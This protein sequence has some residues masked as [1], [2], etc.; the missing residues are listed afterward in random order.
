MRVALVIPTNLYTDS[1]PSFL[2]MSDFPV[3]LA[4]IAAAIKKAGHDV[5]GLNPNNCPGYPSAREMLYDKMKKMLEGQRPQLIGIGGLSTDYAFIKDAIAIVRTLAPEVPIVCGGGIITHDAEFIFNLLKPDYCIIGEAEEVL[6]Q[7]IESLT[8]GNSLLD[9]IPNLGYW[10]DGITK[11]TAPNFDYPPVE[12]RAFPDY[13][14]F[15]P[16]ITVEPSEVALDRAPRNDNGEIPFWRISARCPHCNVTRLF[17]EPLTGEAVA[18][19]NATFLTGCS[20]CG[21]RFKIAVKREGLYPGD[22]AQRAISIQELKSVI[23]NSILTLKAPKESFK[24]LY[25]SLEFTCWQQ[26]RSWSYTGNLGF[27]EGFAA[28][29]ITFLTV[30]ALKEFAPG[31]PASWLSHLK[32]I[33]DGKQFEQV[34]I[35]VV[36]NNLDDTI[37]SY[38]ATL[39]PV[40]LAIIGESLRYPEE[41]YVHAPNLKNRQAEVVHRLRYMTHALVVDELDAEWL[42]N[43]GIV[44]ALWWVGALPVRTI[45]MEA[46]SP[47]QNIAHFSG[48]LYGERER[49]LQHPQLQDVLI[50]QQPLEEDANLPVQFDQLNHQVIDILN[51]NVSF[52][53]QLLHVHVEGL[54]LLRRQSFALWIEGLKHGC[55]VVNLPSF[56]LAYAGRVYEG[57]AAGRPVISWEISDRPRTRALFENGKEILLFSKDDPEQLAEQILRIQRDP[58]FA[59]LISTNVRNKMLR[60]HTIE[61]RVAQILKWIETGEEPNYGEN[62]FE[63]EVARDCGNIAG[64]AMSTPDNFIKIASITPG[65][66]R[67]SGEKFIE[68]GNV[69]EAISAYSKGVRLFPDKIDLWQQLRR[70]TQLT[71]DT[72]TVNRTTGRIDAISSAKRVEE[73]ANAAKSELFFTQKVTI[74]IVSDRLEVILPRCKGNKVLH[75]G[76]TDNPI[77]DTST[78]LHI[79]LSKVC[80]E[81]DGLDVDA[82]GLEKLRQHVYGRYFTDARQVTDEYDVLLVPETIEHV[83]NVR[84]FLESLSKIRF[85]Y[86]MIT[87][88]N[89]FLPNDNGNHLEEPGQYVE[90][91]HPDHNSWFSPYTLKN[92]ITKFTDWK[93]VESY[94][95]NNQSMVGCLCERPKAWEL[96]KIPKKAHFYWGN[97]TTSFLRYLSVYSFH[98]LNPDW[99]INI[100]IPSE[101]YKGDVPWGTGEGYDGT[102]FSG[103]D[104][105]DA[106]YSLPGIAI[107]EVDFSVFPQINAAP[108]NYKSDFFRWHIL[109]IE[110]GLYSDI[111]LLYFRPM[112]D[113]YFNQHVNRDVDCAICLQYAG[114]IIGFLLS[115]PSNQ[116]FRRVFDASISAF[117]TTTYQAIG[118]PLVNQ[119]FPSEKSIQEQLPELKFINMPMDVVYALDHSKIPDIFQTDDMSRLSEKTI[120]IHWYA[121]HPVSQHFNNILTEENYK[122]YKSIITNKIVDILGDSKE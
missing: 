27:E 119:L 109:S 116:F 47:S 7:L 26:A 23:Q 50:K 28:N 54:R 13:S 11:F 89:A 33:C 87:A 79:Q 5:I 51:K 55:A 100:Y 103:R 19:G 61:K 110:G 70:L 45:S 66:I 22:L 83:D 32:A 107:K 118:A 85:K 49:W 2:A 52:S 62:A 96:N 101:S 86:C 25:I 17:R 31:D 114:N 21:K 44:K 15:E 63:Q 37:L 16:E 65:N 95:M 68:L 88:P 39:A 6:V 112:N 69:Q 29:G 104:Y 41:V 67:E 20:F 9:S 111:D 99:E 36:H 43:R 38:I 115:A 81:L 48:A 113:L 40:R 77:F 73:I 3:G 71:G 4:Y 105:S 94:L 24:V 56:V 10:R 1:Y 76:C 60:Y 64:S 91:V 108:E 18:S 34:W 42:N 117:N 57:M 74:K 14:P 122:D 80:R 98:K 53:P 120:G 59:D 121:G 92:C 72:D 35:E 78:N 90:Y 102:Q 8:S 93:V 97:D 12:N 30:P 82:E 84:D 46:S 58:G 75:V 106:L